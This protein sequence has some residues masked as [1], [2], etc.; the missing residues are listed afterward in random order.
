[1]HFLLLKILYIV[2]FIRYPRYKKKYRYYIRD[3]YYSRLYQFK[4]LIK[5]YLKKSK[6]KIIEYNGEFQQE[7]T[8]VL[9]F[10]YW[11][12]CNGTLQKTISS[13]HTKQIYFF[14][15]YHEER[16]EKRDWEIYTKD[17]TIPNMMHSVTFSFTKW[18]RVPLKAHYKNDQFVFSKPILLLANKY[19][20]EWNEAPL[21]F[22]K[23]DTLNKIIEKYKS[24]YQIIYN[25]PLAKHIVSDNSDVLDLNEHQWLRDNHPEVILLDDLYEKFK[26]Y[27]NNFNHLQL[28]VYANCSHFVSVHG[29]T[30]AL[31]SYFGGI[32]IILSKSGIEHQF[33]E[34]HT[35]FPALSGAK[36]LHAKTEEELFNYLQIYY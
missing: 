4:Y 21:N 10:A 13:K 3:N 17:Y 23:I 2:S 9:P 20:V 18:K 15:N 8:F 27:V 33:N 24:K 35:I 6:Y 29:G 11:H 30:A 12:H 28:M 36:I 31:A 22:L 26:A 7:L 34:F 19:N 1:M 14:S 25:R 16:H 5:D 32:N